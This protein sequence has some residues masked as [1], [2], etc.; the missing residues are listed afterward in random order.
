MILYQGVSRIDGK[1]IV[2][3]ATGYGRA[4]K[5]TKTGPMV[6]TWILR[7]D[8]SPISAIMTGAD[9]SICGSCPHRGPL[10]N[11]SCYVNVGKAPSNVWKAFKRGRY[12]CVEDLATFGQNK[13]IRL[14][15]YGDPAAVPSDVWRTLVSQ[16]RTWTG[17]THHWKL[18]PSLKGLLMAS[19]DSPS[20]YQLATMKGWRTFR[21]TS[22]MEGLEKEIF[23]PASEEMN[24]R[25][26]CVKCGLCNGQQGDAR[27][28]IVILAHGV[29][30]GLV[31]G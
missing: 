16:A 8:V 31:T 3:I 13:K 6:Q 1:P 4:S 25:T 26:T 27:K 29:K 11:R 18:R 30:K 19:V 10:G 5:N 12:G 24:H 15:A 23:C 20:E 22:K 17:Y 2:A 21:V 28:N 7:S 9:E 14:G